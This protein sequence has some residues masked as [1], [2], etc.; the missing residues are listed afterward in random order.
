MSKKTTFLFRTILLIIP[1]LGFLM[2][3]SYETGAP[4]GYTGSPG[5]GNSCVA[6]H[7]GTSSTNAYNNVS[8]ISSNIPASGYVL[9]QIYTITVTPNSSAPKHGFEITAENASNVKVGS[10]TTTAQTRYP[11][12][13][14]TSL[15]H[16][17]PLSSGVWS[18]DWVAPSTSQGAITFYAAINAVNG[19]SNAYDNQDFPITTS[20]TVSEAT[21]NI[22]EVHNFFSL[23]ANPVTTTLTVSLADNVGKGTY[24]IYTLSGKMLVQNAF[25]NTN[26]LIIS[27]EKLKKGLYILKIS[28]ATARQELKFIKK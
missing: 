27:T 24:S 23:N 14:H 7:F 17:A 19:D 11:A 16:N 10:F 25:F 2:I 18:F 8:T 26:T 20:I 13:A 9:G 6:C 1:I 12:T 22:A 28:T 4:E 21:A 3:T 15:T 5:D